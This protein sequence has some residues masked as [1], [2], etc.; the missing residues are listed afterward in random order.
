MT[1]GTEVLVVG[2]GPAGY[3]ATAACARADLDV[4]LLAVDPTAAWTQTYGAW[5]DELDQVGLAHV[6]ERAWPDTRVRTIG[7]QYRAVG[8]TYCLIDN[9]RLRD[10]LWSVASDGGASREAGRAVAIDCDDDRVEV[11]TADGARRT[12][13]VVIDATGQPPVFG[14]RPRGRLAYQTAYGVVATFDTPPVPPGAMC[15]MDFDATPFGDDGPP[16]FLYAMDLSDDRWLVEETSLARRPG[17]PLGLLEQRLRRRLDARGCVPREVHSTERVA[18]AMDAPL[19]GGRPPGVTA[20]GAAAAL[21]H[22]ATGYQVATALRRAPPL[23]AAL[24][25]ALRA[26]TATPLRAAAAGT[27]AVWSVSLRRRHALFRL[28]LEVLLQLDMAATQRFFAAF[29]ALPAE[30]W[31]GYV[32]WSSS[33]AQL[34]ATMLRLMVALPGDVRADVLRAVARQESLRPLVAAVVPSLISP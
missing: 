6:V 31:H 3:A 11:T 4:T 26:P 1:P 13:R 5:R 34:Q 15:L 29:F 22:P 8:R 18:F 2:A 14:P 16:T 12:A 20:F 24:H 7:P 27:A 9:D 21:V 10:T 25:A 23:A 32:S 33:P 19:P 17:T 30:Q 28:G